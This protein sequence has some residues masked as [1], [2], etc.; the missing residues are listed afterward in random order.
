MAATS[1][2]SSDLAVYSSFQLWKPVYTL[3][4]SETRFSTSLE[5]G[6][7]VA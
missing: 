5:S 7:P 1:L 4:E 2:F 3:V 6:L